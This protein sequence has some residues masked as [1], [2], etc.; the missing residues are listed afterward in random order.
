MENPVT[1]AF[2]LPPA[3]SPVQAGVD[4][5]LA[6]V[7]GTVFWSADGSEAI[8]LLRDDHYAVAVNSDGDTRSA[9]LTY[10]KPEND[11]ERGW[12]TGWEC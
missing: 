5:V 9:Y 3:D 7:A 12:T 1:T 6:A 11:D 8:V 2:T 4:H 10:V